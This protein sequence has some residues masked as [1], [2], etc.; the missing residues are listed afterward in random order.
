MKNLFV[1]VLT[2]SVFSTSYAM[3]CMSSD[4]SKQMIKAKVSASVATLNYEGSEYARL[5]LREVKGTTA[6]YRSVG[7]LSHALTVTTH[8]NNVSKAKLYQ[9]GKGGTKLV[10]EM[11]ICK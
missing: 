1:A 11:E 8:A 7:E 10:M 4:R 9:I 6:L 3:T 2:L 5:Y